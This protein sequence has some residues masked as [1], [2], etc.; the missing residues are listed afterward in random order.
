MIESK[1]IDEK[2]EFW[3]YYPGRE[4]INVSA[5]Q[6]ILLD[7]LIQLRPHSFEGFKM[8]MLSKEDL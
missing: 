5:E 8:M 1:T 2:M 7:A 3:V 6:Y 4:W